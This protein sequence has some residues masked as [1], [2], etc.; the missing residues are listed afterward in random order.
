MRDK[1]WRDSGEEPNYRH[2]AQ[3]LSNGKPVVCGTSCM[4]EFDAVKGTC[5]QCG[6]EVVCSPVIGDK[7]K[8]CILCAPK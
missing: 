6:R 3:F 4:Y 5:I 7:P 2:L 8:L 1:K